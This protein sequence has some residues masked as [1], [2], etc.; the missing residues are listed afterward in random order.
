M[1]GRIGELAGRAA[2]AA[3]N[4]VEKAVRN[5][6]DELSDRAGKVRDV[7]AERQRDVFEKVR[8]AV[9]ETGSQ[10]AKEAEEAVGMLQVEDRIEE[11]G[12]G[13]S[14]KLQAGIDG[15]GLGIAGRLQGTQTITKDAD[16][17]F[18]L[19]VNGQ[20]GAGLM[21]RLGATGAGA[22][23]S[24]F[25]NAGATVEF[26]FATA[27]EAADAA[28]MF[29]GPKLGGISGLVDGGLKEAID[30]VISNPEIF[31]KN[32]SAFELSG[33]VSGDL[34]A[35]LGV[36]GGKLG[37][38]LQGLLQGRADA[39]ARIEFK[40]GEAPQLALRQTVQVNGNASAN[41][42]AGASVGGT[43]KMM[44]EERFELPQ[45]LDPLDVV[46]DPE[47]TANRIADSAKRTGELSVTLSGMGHA[48]KTLGA[49]GSKVGG[50][51]TGGD[52]LETE[53]KLTGKARDVLESGGLKAA[54]DGDLQLA[55]DR[56]SPVVTVEAKVAP[57]RIQE[58]G[59]TLEGGI[60]LASAGISL[61]G[62][63]TDKQAPIA[64]AS[65][66]LDEVLQELSDELKRT[67]LKLP[68]AG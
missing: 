63:L 10:I 38:G 14:Y 66:T 1:I 58:A 30:G 32:L 17:G 54:L 26:K 15:S 45:G 61:T 52:Q 29:M 21:A 22:R 49:T 37:A 62:T 6:A 42:V 34:A 68:L 7:V 5:V 40:D 43:G 33:G 25:V 56:L 55:L 46:K 8:T 39:S 31:R 11:L 3:K 12:V 27:D 28:R 41:M 24:A 35:Q 65:G 20:A 53:L 9:T 19:A 50:K 47:G 67:R 2:Y 60:G 44:I 51:G 13:D 18:T 48:S 64:Q 4:T 59:G 36:A 16:G 57:V 23:A